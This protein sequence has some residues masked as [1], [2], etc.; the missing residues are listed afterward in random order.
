MNKYKRKPKKLSRMDNLETQVSLDTRERR[1]TSK[2]ENGNTQ[3]C[4]DDEQ[5]P[6]T[7]S[8]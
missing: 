1:N 6:H 4:N 8:L 3:Y 7:T 2:T 5:E